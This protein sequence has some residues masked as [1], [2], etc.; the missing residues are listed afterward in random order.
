MQSEWQGALRLHTVP[1][2]QQLFPGFYCAVGKQLLGDG[3]VV[4]IQFLDLRIVLAEL[5]QHHRQTKIGR[6]EMEGWINFRPPV[7]ELFEVAIAKLLRW[8]DDGALAKIIPRGDLDNACLAAPCPVQRLLK[9][10]AVL[11]V[12]IPV[13]VM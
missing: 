8:F 13:A 1:Q 10:L 9:G 3:I 2:C 6:D 11:I 4:G 12:E 7:L 5:V